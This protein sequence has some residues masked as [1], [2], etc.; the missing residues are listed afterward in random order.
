VD[1]DWDYFA[2][3]FT[4]VFTKHITGVSEQDG[5]MIMVLE[6]EEAVLQ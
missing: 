5:N 3:V 1:T 6:A 2:L 4:P